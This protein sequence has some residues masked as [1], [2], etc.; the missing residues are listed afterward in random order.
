MTKGKNVDSKIVSNSK[1]LSRHLFG[2]TS[3]GI[4]TTHKHRVQRS[5]GALCYYITHYIT[6]LLYREIW[7]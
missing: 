1:V 5:V 4:I 3:D 7:R 2:E 6:V